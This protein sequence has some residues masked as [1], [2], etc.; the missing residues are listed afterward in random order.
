MTTQ[1]GGPDGTCC[2]SSKGLAVNAGELEREVGVRAP[3]HRCGPTHGPLALCP[4]GL[5]DKQ[6]VRVLAQLCA[7]ELCVLRSGLAALG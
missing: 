6:E 3:G 2:R 1:G 4:A 7:E 5:W